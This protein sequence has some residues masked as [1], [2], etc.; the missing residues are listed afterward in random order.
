MNGTSVWEELLG[1][2]IFRATEAHGWIVGVVVGGAVATVFLLWLLAWWCCCRRREAAERVVR[3]AGFRGFGA[4]M[5]VAGTK[6]D[7]QELR[8]LI[9]TA[10]EVARHKNEALGDLSGK[11]AK[12]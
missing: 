5:R 9:P 11:Y 1:S 7:A 2:S 12:K 4:T 3:R 10:A 8:T 6:V